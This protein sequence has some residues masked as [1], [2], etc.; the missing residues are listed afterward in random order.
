[1]KKFIPLS[2]L[3]TL[4]ALTLVTATAPHER[5][6]GENARLV[7]LHGAW[8]W[9]AMVMFLAAGVV[10]LAGLLTRHQALHD[11]SLAL[12]RTALL[13]WIGFLPQSLFLMQANWNGLFLEE[14]RFRIPLNLAVTGLLVQVGIS[15][16]PR[17]YASVV[18]LF[19]AGAL[20]WIMNGVQ[21]VLHPEGPIQ[22]STSTSI[23]LFFYALLALM[24]ALA[25]QVA[26]VWRNS[27]RKTKPVQVIV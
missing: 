24:I 16:F 11:W 27:G 18:N 26:Y 1:M 20:F 17:R 23:Q 22:N 12:G 19:F 8:V 10:G 6:L 25:V 13:L 2:L 9:T 3:L 5:T 7:Y 14:P 4:A 15:F 21:T